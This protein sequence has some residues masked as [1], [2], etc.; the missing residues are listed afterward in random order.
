MVEK[1]IFIKGLE[2]QYL[3]NKL[4]QYDQQIY[5]FKVVNQ[6][7]E[8]NLKT[9]IDLSNKTNVKLPIWVSVDT[10]F[11]LVVKSTCLVKRIFERNIIYTT[12]VVFVPYHNEDKS[13]KGY[14]TRLGQIV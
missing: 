12:N 10:C 8:N 6:S 13:V 9:L 7:N 4:N 1:S 2:I 5:Y 3:S 14:Y 11:N